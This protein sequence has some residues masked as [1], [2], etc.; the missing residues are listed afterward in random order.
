ME[1]LKE[2]RVRRRKE[3]RVGGK[4][5]ERAGEREEGKEGTKCRKGQSLSPQN[6]Q[7]RWQVKGIDREK[8]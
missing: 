1:P 4:E 3:G 7:S 8:T 6:F 5:G 2:R